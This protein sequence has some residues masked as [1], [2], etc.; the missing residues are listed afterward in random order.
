M[1][2]TRIRTKPPGQ[3]PLEGMELIETPAR[4]EKPVDDAFN[5]FWEAYPRKVDKYQAR[6]IWDK[7]MQDRTVKVDEIFTGLRNQ[8]PTLL[9]N[10][11][12]VPHPA[13]WLRHRRWND[14][15]EDISPR[16]PTQ[17]ER[18]YAAAIDRYYKEG[19]L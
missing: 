7:L 8:L 9:L 2:R 18:L 17:A 11:P 4:K 1:K 16:Q 13:T 19:K 15:V 5:A 3:M 14:R 10:G 12:F 6:L